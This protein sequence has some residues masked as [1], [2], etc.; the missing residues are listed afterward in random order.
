MYK[1]KKVITNFPSP[2]SDFAVLPLI[3][4]AFL[5]NMPLYFVLLIRKVYGLIKKYLNNKKK[6]K[7]TIESTLEVSK[8]NDES[9][10]MLTSPNSNSPE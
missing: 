6:P 5:T 9:Q 3:A 10:Q 4:V 1:L 7:K 2:D 8:Q